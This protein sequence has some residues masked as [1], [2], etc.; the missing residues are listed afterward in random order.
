[1]PDVTIAL[2]ALMAF[3]IVGSVVAV[4]TPDLLSAVIC[5]GAVGFALSVIDLLL[6]APD[7]GLT[8]AVVEILALVVIIRTVKTRRDTYHAMSRDTRT[9]AVVVASLGLLLAI[10]YFAL[11]GMAPFGQPLMLMSK[12]YLETGL[13][14]IGAVNYV[15][16]IVIDF[17]GY[18]TL[19]EATIIFA[20][21]VGAYTVL[22]PVGRKREAA[23]NESDR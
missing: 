15:T 22:R 7:L 12:P 11:Q 16:S 18:D 13:S 20:A 3:M 2:Y 23:G 17:R 21:I 8:L 5:V 14:R 4:E 19:G 10:A 1:M 9:I 6:C